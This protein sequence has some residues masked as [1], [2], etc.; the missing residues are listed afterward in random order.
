[1]AH[2]GASR[3]VSAHLG[4]SL[5]RPSR[6][7]SRGACRRMSAHVGACR[8]MSAHVGACRRVSAHLGASRRISAAGLLQLGEGEAADGVL[9]HAAKQVA[10][11]AGEADPPARPEPPPHARLGRALRRPR[12]APALG[13]LPPL[14]GDGARLPA[15]EPPVL[16]AAGQ[17]RGDLGCSRARLEPP[18]RSARPPST[19]S[20]S[21]ARGPPSRSGAYG[22]SPPQI[23]RSSSSVA[24]P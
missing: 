4:A 20:P 7:A 5:S 2:L 11:E 21:A 10:R 12:A 9:R 17:P 15:L 16:H 13:V 18:P 23:G 1:M 8:R 19:A 22:P 14:L 24:Q 3:R 6:G